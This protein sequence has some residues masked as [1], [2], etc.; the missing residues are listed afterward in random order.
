MT[1]AAATRRDVEKEIALLHERVS[2]LE[3]KMANGTRVSEG[4]IGAIKERLNALKTVPPA[5]V[6]RVWTTDE[7]FQGEV[8]L[9]VESVMPSFSRPALVSSRP[10]SWTAN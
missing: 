4:D 5:R 9:D 2:A 10:L 3:A 8:P 1:E 7:N 6:R